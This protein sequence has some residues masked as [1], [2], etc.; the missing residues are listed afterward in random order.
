MGRFI[1]EVGEH[2]WPAAYVLVNTSIKV[3]LDSQGQLGTF[4]HI[5]NNFSVDSTS[6]TDLDRLLGVLVLAAVK[7]PTS[8]LND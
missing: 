5:V 2:C 1:C 4:E 3:V 6:V 7:P 8:Q